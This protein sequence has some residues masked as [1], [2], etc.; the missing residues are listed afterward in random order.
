M[1]RRS[2]WRRRTRI[3]AASF[4]TAAFAVV[5]GFAVQN[6]MRA[7]QYQYLL[8]TGYRHAFAE[9]ATAA[10]EL[11]TALQKAS[12]ATTPALFSSLCTQAYGKALSAQMAL[13]E[14]PYGN[15]E[16]EQTAA[17]LAKAGDYAM[18]LSRGAYDAQTCTQ[19][20]RS[21]LH[22]LAQTASTLAD[23]LQ[24]LQSDLDGRTVTLEIWR[25]YAPASPAFPA[26][27]LRSRRAPRFRRWR[28]ISRRCPPWSTTAPSPST[29]PTARPSAWKG[30]LWA[31]QDEARRRPR[32]FWTCA[33][34]S[35]HWSPTGRAPCPPGGFSAAVDGGEVYV[36]VTKQGAQVLQVTNS[37]PV[38]GAALS[39]E[40]AIQA[41]AEFLLQRGYANM[42]HSYS[43]DLGDVLTV[44]FAPRQD[45]VYCYPDLIKVSVALDNGGLIGF[46]S[47]GYLMNHRVRDLPA[48]AVTADQARSAVG[49]ALKVLA[50]QL[51]V[52]PTGGEHEV[53]CHEF[54]CETETGSHM[55]VYLN[56]A[57]G[58]EEN[59]L[60][61]LE[62]ESGTLTL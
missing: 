46:Q 5:L 43:I 16:L 31:G 50:H 30:C 33:R 10:G 49:D 38:S 2:H 27:L 39:R 32:P 47:E 1:N 57:T 29:C 35:S 51:A 8:D 13:G 42:D 40:A 28:Q 37:R 52:I 22:A 15:V 60:L 36:E 26:R 20:E 19:E 21:G 44:H 24:S 45:G 9:L 7:Q 58:Q 23:A 3:R 14:L 17:F 25:R 48:P 12:Y 41:A 18:A 4:L 11:D 62:D 53:L 61:L 56:A 59:I 54:K 6:H 34:R 55:L